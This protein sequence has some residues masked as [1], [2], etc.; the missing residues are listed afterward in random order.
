[1]ESALPG[2]HDAAMVYSG[3]NLLGEPG[4]RITIVGLGKI[5]I[6]LGLALRE[7]TPQAQRIG[8]D[9]NPWRAREAL[10]RQAVDRIDGSL[11]G[12]CEGS[13]LILLALPLA[14]MERTLRAIAPI[15]AEGTLVLDTAELKAPV[16]AWARHHLPPTVPFIGGHPILRPDVG[17]EPGPDLFRDALF[18]LTPPAQAPAWA[19]EAAAGL[20]H[21]I[22]ARPFFIDPVEHDGWMAALE[23]LPSLLSAALLSVWSAAPAR[24]EMPQAIGSRFA[25]MTADLPDAPSGRLAAMANRESLLYWL[26]RLLEALG[27]LREALTD[28]ENEA[29]LEDFFRSADRIREAW[30]KSR[31]ESLQ[32][33]P[34]PADPP[35]LLETMLKLR[36]LRPSRKQ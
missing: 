36:S 11:P 18:C 2:I 16:L 1:M 7:A 13:D 23:Q 8:H 9:P 29:A 21:R 12:A 24:R 31:H 5:G 3:R 27:R 22:G 6:S 19:V 10:R 15:L 17:E 14:D 35:G 34:I 33:L 26:D 4:M 30:L 28:V 32:A 20:A 25:R